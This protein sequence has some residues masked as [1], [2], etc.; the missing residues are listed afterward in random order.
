MKN[1]PHLAELRS[2]VCGPPLMAQAHRIIASTQGER[3]N[4]DSRD[5]GRAALR[6]GRVSKRGS[7]LPNRAG[8]GTIRTLALRDGYEDAT[9]QTGPWKRNTLNIKG[10]CQCGQGFSP[11]FPPRTRFRPRAAAALMALVIVAADSPS[12]AF[13]QSPAKLLQNATG[14]YGDPTATTP[15]PSV[16]PLA[17]IA[18]KREE[19]AARLATVKQRIES[20][21]ASGTEAQ[22]VQV[23]EVLTREENLL[24]QIDLALVQQETKRKQ[25]DE[26]RA[27]QDKVSADIET[28]RT[29]GPSA[30]NA[31]TILYLD[32]TRNEL[33]THQQRGE[34][35][36]RSLTAARTAVED[37][38]KLFDEREKSRRRAKEQLDT[39][40]DESGKQSLA[41]ALNIAELESRLARESLT[42]REVELANQEI[43]TKTYELRLTLLSERVTDAEARARFTRAELTD[44]KNEVAEEKDDAEEA[45]RS[46]ERRLG[47]A[48][49]ELTKVRN[50]LSSSSMNEVHVA[51]V[52]AARLMLGKWEVE[53]TLMSDRVGRLLQL[54]TF[55]ESRYSVWN[56]RLSRAELL[57][58]A[59][60]WQKRKSEYETYAHLRSGEVAELRN[61]LVEIENRAKAAVETN[62]ELVNVLQR[63]KKV[64]EERI[65]RQEYSLERTQRRIRLVQNLLTDID[66]RT[67]TVSLSERFAAVWGAVVGV[68]HYELFTTS[69]D[70]PITVAK[71]VIGLICILGG[72]YV[73]RFLSG[74]AARR[75]FPRLGLDAGASEAVKTLVFYGLVLLFFLIS[76]NIVNVP[77]TAFTIAG[78]ALAI[79][80]GFGSQ[81]LMNNF[82]SGLILLAERPI[83]VGDLIE[84]DGVMGTVSR[85]GTRSTAVKSPMNVDII[86]PNSKLL[87][88]RVTNW[89]LSDDLFC[90]NISVGIAY[91]SNTREAAKL[92]RKALDEHGKVI[93]KPEP[94]VYFSEFGDNALIFHAWFWIRMRTMRQRRIIESDLRFR[95]DAL[96]RE[97]KITIAFPQRDVHLDTLKPLDVRL[98]PPEEPPGA[99]D[100]K[101]AA[102]GRIDATE[103]PPGGTSQAADGKSSKS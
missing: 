88:N 57:N 28:F 99:E 58:I 21:K 80:V 13:A 12:L 52:E 41:N 34:T 46:I 95:I 61:D 90:T 67:K 11:G 81:N 6:V 24:S 7:C 98:L 43:V 75:V 94:M 62:G 33:H 17:E 15:A 84:V 38:K 49:E 25:L 56:G 19:I 48:E 39:A 64:V 36:Q 45:K 93:S 4:P 9:P 27:Q 68:W 18:R 1:E 66:N 73:S 71:I 16:D 2:A 76:L 20:I 97:G 23:P 87:E 82:M 26:N 91:G 101:P 77:L 83:R 50:A 35:I 53:Q 31:G 70:A 59:S 89:T 54:D 22:P 51:M 72:L 47:E 85:V 55:W 5:E 86:I 92:I 40:T 32:E 100:G 102:A 29:V 103:S 63:Q 8:R 3:T 37:A 10:L 79:G 74:W 96:F 14:Q 60:E 42:L 69:D 78:G 44:R 30:P 65:A